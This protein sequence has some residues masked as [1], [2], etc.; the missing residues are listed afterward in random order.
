MLE[1]IKPNYIASR[2]NEVLENN[3]QSISNSYPINLH[4]VDNVINELFKVYNDLN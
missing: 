1:N 3:I 4:E 2:I